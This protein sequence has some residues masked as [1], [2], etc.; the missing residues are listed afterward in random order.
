GGD[1]FTLDGV[2]FSVADPAAVVAP[3][4]AQ[5]LADARSKATELAGAVIAALRDAGAGDEDLR[6]TG[7]NLWH[8]QRE[9]QFVATNQLRVTVA[10]DDVGP[11][12]DVAGRAGGDEFTLDG[13]TFSVADPA[14]LVAPLR[15]QALADARSKADELAEAEG[16]TVGLALSITEGGSGGHVPTF[17]AR[18]AMAAAPPVEVGAESLSLSVTVTYEIS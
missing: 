17:K 13:V 8:D 16:A 4:R 12:I 2:T 6:T 1:E 11:R 9:R 10:A 3:L 5:A 7:I 14:A 18:T 15:Q